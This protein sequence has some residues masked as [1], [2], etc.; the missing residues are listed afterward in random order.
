[1][2][3]NI[4][5]EISKSIKCINWDIDEA[6]NQINFIFDHEHTT[7]DNSIETL[8]SISSDIDKIKMLLNLLR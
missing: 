6:R 7:I 4:K 8:N 3:Q 5:T 2:K 1:M